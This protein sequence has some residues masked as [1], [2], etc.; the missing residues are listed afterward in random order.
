MATAPLPDQLVMPLAKDSRIICPC[1]ARMV[2]E[3]FCAKLDGSWQW[4]L[5]WRCAHDHLSNVL[6]LPDD[7]C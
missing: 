3:K 6:P 5:Y 4:W 7:C 2:P 1:G